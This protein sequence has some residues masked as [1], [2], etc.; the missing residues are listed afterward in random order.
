MKCYYPWDEKGS[1][2][3]DVIY[4]RGEKKL[5]EYLRSLANDG[6]RA[7]FYRKAMSAKVSFDD[8]FTLDSL[9][10]KLGTDTSKL[11]QNKLVDKVFNVKLEE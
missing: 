4:F 9:F 1:N 7:I 6:E 2:R 3:K 5:I 10:Q 8:I 11:T